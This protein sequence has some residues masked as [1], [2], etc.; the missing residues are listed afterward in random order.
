MHMHI[1]MHMMPMHMPMHT[2][3]HMHMHMYMPLV[4]PPTPG[5][6]SIDEHT[7]TVSNRALL[8]SDPETPAGVNQ[9]GTLPT[10]SQS[11]TRRYSEAGRPVT[12]TGLTHTAG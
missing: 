12:L 4:P 2:H 6:P 10:S 11:V 8:T 3:M 1:P 7:V 5:G 9:V